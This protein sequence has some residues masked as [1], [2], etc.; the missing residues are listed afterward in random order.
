[1]RLVVLGICSLLVTSCGEDKEKVAQSRAQQAKIAELE[2]QVATLRVSLDDAPTQDPTAAL[3]AAEKELA[4]VRESIESLQ[5]ELE[6][7]KA[8]NE[9][10]KRDFMLYRKKYV[11]SN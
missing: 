10:V 1:M 7:V 6:S 11:I 5:N 9:Q 4:S 3:E 2:A 8:E